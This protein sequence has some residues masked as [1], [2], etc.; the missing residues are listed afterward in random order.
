MK[1]EACTSN[2]EKYAENNE[3]G[4]FSISNLLSANN[5]KT[6]PINDSKNS[7]KFVDFPIKN[8][9]ENTII[10]EKSVNSMNF[11]LMLLQQLR[12]SNSTETD[13]ND[14]FVDQKS[15]KTTKNRCENLMNYQTVNKIQ[16][17]TNSANYINCSNPQLEPITRWPP[18]KVNSA[19]Q[20]L[21]MAKHSSLFLIFFKIVHFGIEFQNKK[22]RN[23]LKRN[24]SE[25]LNWSFISIVHISCFKKPLKMYRL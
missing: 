4:A 16:S 10:E 23:I 6:S 14:D 3:S 12:N 17:F 5:S 7:Q 25:F 11:S 18:E 8:N 15:L 9:S 21:M 1:I 24:I 13:I 19:E 20:C 22:F 2:P